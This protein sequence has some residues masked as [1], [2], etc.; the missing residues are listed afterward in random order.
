[1]NLELSQNEVAMVL[2][3]LNYA[4]ECNSEHIETQGDDLA[5][6]VKEQHTLI[7]EI[8]KQVDNADTPKQSVK[9]FREC[10]DY[11]SRMFCELRSDVTEDL[12]FILNGN[13]STEVIKS[14]FAES[15]FIYCK[16]NDQD[17][18]YDTLTTLIETNGTPLESEIGYKSD[19]WYGLNCTY[20]N[21]SK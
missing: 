7:D 17:F 15:R 9:Y 20:S 21:D 5:N 4:V 13:D 16:Y 8:E 19:E 11:M 2:E 6:Y 18:M 10:L 1:M 14:I 3:A 12:D